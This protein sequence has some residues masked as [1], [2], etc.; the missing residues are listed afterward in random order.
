MEEHENLI[1]SGNDVGTVTGK[2]L[3]FLEI[4]AAAGRRASLKS[5]QS[6]TGLRLLVFGPPDQK[7]LTC[8]RIY[9]GSARNTKDSGAMLKKIL[10][11][12][13]EEPLFCQYER[14][15]AL[16]CLIVEGLPGSWRPETGVSRRIK[17]KVR[18]LIAKVKRKPGAEG[19]SL[20]KQ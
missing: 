4:L 15:M 12:C 14:S 16:L 1:R 20:R 11:E 9:W 17:E 10:A 7:I 5:E 3:V 8:Y 19:G 6:E 2:R 18:P 13:M